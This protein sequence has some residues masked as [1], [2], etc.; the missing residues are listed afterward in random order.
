[1]PVRH[2]TDSAVRSIQASH[3]QVD[4]WAT[5][6]QGF[7]LRVSPGG[8]KAWVLRY[9]LDGRQSRLTL[10]V[11]PHLT[12]AD[13]RSQAK[14][15]LGDVAH[16]TDPAALKQVER[17]AGTFGALAEVYIEKHAKVK[18]RSWEADERIIKAELL[19]VL[20]HLKVKNISRG[21]V[22]ELVEAVVE[23]GAPIMANRVLA[24]IRKM[25]NVAIDRE[26]IATN[27]ASR[28]AKPSV[29]RQ[30]D[31]VLTED[32]VRAL[33]LALDAEGALRPLLGAYFK[34]RLLTAQRGQE[35][36]LMRW[37]DIDLERGWWTQPAETTKNGLSHRVP[38]TPI[39][40][41]LLRELAREADET[42]AAINHWRARKKL[43]PVT[44]SVW[45]FPSPRRDHGD[46]PLQRN[47]QNAVERL[48]ATSGVDFRA[49]DLRRTAAS[50]M[51]SAGVQRLVIKKILNHVERDVTAVYDRHSYDAEKRQGLETWARTLESILAAPGTGR[52]VLPFG[53]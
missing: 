40:I 3:R 33:W 28:M 14:Q 42:L 7:G 49:H 53:R 45:V 39:V 21:Q 13:A 17:E 9:R 1:M 6:L 34:L 47:L 38:L 36:G 22:R 32:E 5:D 18:K 29:E 30:R 35:V 27:V 46:L 19:P 43:E 8:R 52:K 48:R 20:R 41:K 23:R 44:P 16:H 11:Y 15:A 50:Y 4:Y 24:L 26:W 12:L 31:R 51:A 2:L 37:S 25:L 10:G